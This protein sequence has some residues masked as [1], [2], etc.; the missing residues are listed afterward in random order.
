METGIANLVNFKNLF[1][2]FRGQFTDK[3]NNAGRQTAN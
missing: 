1:K 2:K 3:I